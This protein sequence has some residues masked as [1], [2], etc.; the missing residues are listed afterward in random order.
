MNDI[1]DDVFD[2]ATLEAADTAEM[3]VLHPANDKPTNW[4][5]TF[6]GPGHPKT[7][8]QSERDSRKRLEEQRRIQQA[9]INGKKW[10]ADEKSTDELRAEN[11]RFVV[12][13]IVGWSPV[14]VNGVDY[15]FTVENATKL[16]ANPKQGKLYM[17]CLNFLGGDDSFFG[18]SGQTSSPGPNT[19]SASTAAPKTAA[20]NVST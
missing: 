20:R 9:Q 5:I 8:E 10:K 4:T 15:P 3:V 16:L 2:A 14:K 7:I 11:V 13:R 19:G 12:E 18:A 1:A 17:Q 6:A